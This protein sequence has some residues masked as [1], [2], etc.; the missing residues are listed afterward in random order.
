M[1]GWE[2]VEDLKLPIYLVESMP[3]RVMVAIIELIVKYQVE[4]QRDPPA[5]VEQ[6]F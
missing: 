2:D 1:M 6:T 3:L 5:K 4:L